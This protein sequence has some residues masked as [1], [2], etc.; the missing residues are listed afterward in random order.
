MECNSTRKYCFLLTIMSESSADSVFSEK[1]KELFNEDDLEKLLV[2]K[3]SLRNR[4][5]DEKLS[6]K[7][8]ICKYLLNQ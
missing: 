8:G 5:K 1:D 7:A 2:I 4:L 6:E 3:S